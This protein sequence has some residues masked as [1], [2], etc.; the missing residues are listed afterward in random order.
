MLVMVTPDR[1]GIGLAPID[2]DRLWHTTAADGVG[3]EAPG[4]VFVAVLH[5]EEI[6]GMASLVHSA[7]KILPLPV[8]FHGRLIHAPAV[9]H[10][11][12]PPAACLFQRWGRLEHPALDGGMID[13]DPS[14]LHHLFELAIAQGIR[15]VPPDAC[16]DN[17]CHKVGPLEA[18]HRLS[19][20]FLTLGYRGRSDLR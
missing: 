3:E 20:S 11:L 5:E 18:H 7:I 6:D 4:G 19:P 16:E 8:D 2:G 1:C 15:H 10:R 9:P 13:C 14:F 17:L 12:I